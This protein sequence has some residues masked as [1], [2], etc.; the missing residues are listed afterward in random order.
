MSS[1]SPSS[2][3]ATV[4]NTTE[5]DKTKKENSPMGLWLKKRKDLLENT[6]KDIEGAIPIRGVKK[7]DDEQDEDSDDEEE[8]D[9]AKYTQDQVD[10]IRQIMVTTKRG[11]T[12]EAMQKLI[13]R[14][15]FGDEMM[16]FSTS[17][18]YQVVGAFEND[19][20]KY[21]RNRK[22]TPDKFD[23]LLGFTFTLHQYDVWCHDNEGDFGGDTMIASLARMWKTLLQKTDDQLGI[24]SEYTRPGVTCFLE[25]FKETVE[26]A[27][28][29]PP[30]KFKFK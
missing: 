7:D 26:S 24:D 15:Q 8:E 21:Y 5:S 28:T 14:D 1:P 2:G 9:S 18:S 13:L 23:A 11:K 10:N 29:E 6:Y 4:G 19:F 16:M 22:S 17:Y 30:L 27:Y 3:V 20:K 12:I 25:K